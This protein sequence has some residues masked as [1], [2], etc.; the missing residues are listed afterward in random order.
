[1]NKTFKTFFN[2]RKNCLVVASE[3]ASCFHKMTKKN[4]LT[5]T[6]LISSSLITS[7]ANAYLF[8]GM[9]NIGNNVLKDPADSEIILDLKDATKNNG[10]AL[11][12]GAIGNGNDSVSFGAGDFW[13]PLGSLSTVPTIFFQNQDV[14][15]NGAVV[16]QKMRVIRG[17]GGHEG[18][19]WLNGTILEVTKDSNNKITVTAKNVD[20]LICGDTDPNC[21]YRN[22]KDSDLN[23]DKLKEIVN[24]YGNRLNTY[25]NTDI[26]PQ[27]FNTTATRKL[28]N[29]SRGD[30]SATSTD[31]I[32]G[33][34]Y[35]E[36]EQKVNNVKNELGAA[37]EYISVNPTDTVA[38]PTTSAKA[39]GAR[40]TA[41]GE[42]AVASGSN[43]LAIGH[44]ATTSTAASNS[45]A[46]GA[47]SQANEADI[48]SVGS[49]AV[50]RRVTNLADGVSLNPES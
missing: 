3:H 33:S 16:A 23:F 46:L 19:I 2:K 32:N 48:V 45:I 28:V 27:T 5:A 17:Q 20:H 40:A 9:A 37:N 30:I 6:I 39:Q 47:G 36:L 49:D 44:N 42:N 38:S 24:K 34:Q 15:K 29:V 11:G 4:I 13:K 26:K 43:S 12:E 31:A 22:L 14:R 50:K 1:M 8:G 41:V 25:D 35:F 10:V 18:K 7:N 21:E